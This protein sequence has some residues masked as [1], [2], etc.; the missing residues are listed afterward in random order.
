MVKPHVA[1][2][3]SLEK[4]ISNREEIN[5]KKQKSETSLIVFTLLVQV[6]VGA[7]WAAQWM[8]DSIPLIPY[9]IIGA[10]LGIG[11]LFS[12]AHLGAKRNAWRAPFHL[13]KS[14]L[15]REMLFVGLFG[16]GWLAGFML[17][18]MKWVTSLLGIG[19]IYSMAKVYQLRTMPAWNT[20]RTTAGFFV[21]AALLGHVAM[22]NLLGAKSGDFAVLALLALEL[23]MTLSAKPEA[24][25]SVHRLRV[26]L[27]AVALLGA[28]I[29]SVVPNQLGMWISLSIFLIV[30][31]E[32][33][34]GRWLFYEALKERPI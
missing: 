17:P 26:G 21:T 8:V 3:N 22:V 28:A 9:L 32:Q 14:W 33:I 30:L 23:A 12:F 29:M 15:S 19:L 6:T 1:M 13:K 11:G 20:W 24:Q 5:P 31:I 2:N 34:I 4:K 25:W 18:E 7:F 27:I 10:C 16:A